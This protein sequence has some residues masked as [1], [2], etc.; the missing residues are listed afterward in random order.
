MAKKII[1]LTGSKSKLVFEKLPEDDPRRRCPDITK[2]EHILKWKPHT[3]I[4]DGLK[5]TI[6]YFSK[7]I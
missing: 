4:E 3:E 2:A 1:Q 7:K 5:K 6:E